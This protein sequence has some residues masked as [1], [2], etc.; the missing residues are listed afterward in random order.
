MS[1]LSRS[2]PA[3]GGPNGGPG[4]GGGGISLEVKK[5]EEK[6]YG[7]LRWFLNGNSHLSRFFFFF[8]TF[9]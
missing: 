6:S 5:T 2:P 1:C 9:V 7:V 4:R 8:F 3:G